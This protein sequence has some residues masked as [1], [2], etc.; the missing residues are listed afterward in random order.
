[1]SCSIHHRLACAGS[2]GPQER[3]HLSCPR[4]SWILDFPSKLCF[5]QKN[6]T[7]GWRGDRF[8]LTHRETHT[9]VF[10]RSCFS[11]FRLLQ[12]LCLA[13]W[14]ALWNRG[15]ATVASYYRSET[16]ASKAFL[17]FRWRAETKILTFALLFS[18]IFT[19]KGDPTSRRIFPLNGFKVAF[20]IWIKYNLVI[21][22]QEKPHGT[23]PSPGVFI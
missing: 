16:C 5:A 13:R 3:S 8:P 9:Y 10:H 15:L 1:M 21:W 2:T 20:S 7:S 6:Q 14:A 12:P 19:R 18:S 4:P 11:P 22:A 17:C 23:L